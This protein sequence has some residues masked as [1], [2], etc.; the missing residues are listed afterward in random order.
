MSYRDQSDPFRF[1]LKLNDG[2]NNEDIMGLRRFQSENYEVFE[3]FCQENEGIKL[4]ICITMYNEDKELLDRTLEGIIENL[5]DFDDF[6]LSQREILVII[7]ADGYKVFSKELKKE[8]RLPE[9]IDNDEPE[10]INKWMSLNGKNNYIYCK[11]V[12]FMS[13]N[14]R[15]LIKRNYLNVIFA[16]KKKNAMK[17]NSHLFFFIG[18]CPEF[19]KGS[20][21]VLIDCGTIPRKESLALLYLSLERYP[22]VAAVCGEIRIDKKNMDCFSVLAAQYFEYK[23]SHALDKHF[24]NFFGFITVLPGAFSA[25]RLSCLDSGILNT[26]FKTVLA[27]QDI[28]TFEGNK[29]LAEDRV[30]CLELFVDPSRRNILM[31]VADAVAT[32]D[33]IEDLCT[34]ISQRRRWINGSWFAMM[35]L[36]QNAC[37]CLQTQHNILQKFLFYILIIYYYIVSLMSFF[38][39]SLFYISLYICYTI[40]F[41]NYREIVSYAMFVYSVVLLMILIASM[42]HNRPLIFRTLYQAIS[43]VL[44]CYFCISLICA[45]YGVSQ[46]L[47]SYQP[48]ENNSLILALSLINIL[49]YALPILINLK[50]MFNAIT[51]GLWAYLYYLP[52]YSNLF[53]IFS[54]AN[55]D[56]LTWGN[57]EGES[58]QGLEEQKKHFKFKLLLLFLGG[59]FSVA[60][61]FVKYISDS[62]NQNNNIKRLTNAAS[63]M[64]YIFTFILFFKALFAFIDRIYYIIWVRYQLNKERE[65]Q[66]EKYSNIRRETIRTLNG[67]NDVNLDPNEVNLN[68]KDV[69]LDPNDVNFD[70]K[71]NQRSNNI[72]IHQNIQTEN[73]SPEKKEGENFIPKHDDIKNNNSKDENNSINIEIK[74]VE[75]PNNH[76]PL[77]P[78]DPD[79]SLRN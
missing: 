16:I 61:T 50:M 39:I 75:K 70:D 45:F 8:L 68:H 77:K 58:Q 37:K 66:R 26:Y 35:Y 21:A 72:N 79:H 52:T 42:S 56:D 15:L 76:K 43:L 3:K 13:R 18:F 44:F 27:G 14:N 25:Y 74:Q 57:R 11:L 46:I 69:N 10:E 19:K 60:F 53:L 65:A 38:T 33:G 71:N 31:F 51:R 30:F 6:G 62:D 67:N 48:N 7:I 4:I 29:Y 5:Q 12:T 55:V 64:A 40:A 2:D 47:G 49:S 63:G 41:Y 17:I 23:I 78:V 28:D 34:L 1:S 54:Y 32:T 73:N 59:N 20:Y 36:L 24:E 9:S 22:E